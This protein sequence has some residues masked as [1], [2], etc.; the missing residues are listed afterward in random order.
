MSRVE[1]W[2]KVHSPTRADII[3]P[4]I[5]TMQ[6]LL[7]R[8]V[9]E[10]WHPDQQISVTNLVNAPEWF[11]LRAVEVWLGDPIIEQEDRT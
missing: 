3:R 5:A 4:T 1:E 7:T 10:G 2:E 8:L 9:D 6:E 11:T